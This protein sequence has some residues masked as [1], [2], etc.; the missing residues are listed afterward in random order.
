MIKGKGFEDTKSYYKHCE[1]FFMEIESRQKVRESQKKLITLCSS[2][3]GANYKWLSQ[4][5]TSNWLELV[6]YI[7]NASSKVAT[8]LR[9]IL[10]IKFF[11]N[12]KKGW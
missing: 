5:E 8:S 12:P 9:V 11:S 2:S 10:K 6:S 1:M 7:I 4:L 3:G